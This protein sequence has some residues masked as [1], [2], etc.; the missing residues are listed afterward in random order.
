MTN[1]NAQ[2]PRNFLD[3]I[4]VAISCMCVV[5]CLML[6][7]L[8]SLLSVASGVL[9]GW[10]WLHIVFATMALLV[11]LFAFPKGY[12]VHRSRVPFALTLPALS[13]LWLSIVVGEPHWLEALLVSIGAMMQAF[14]H[15]MNHKLAKR[16]SFQEP[17]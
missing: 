1:Y 8:V 14:A 5:H 11:A 4:G 17:V 9:H 15:L 7:V 3:K 2:K 13:L 6:P 10:E 12:Q 16:F